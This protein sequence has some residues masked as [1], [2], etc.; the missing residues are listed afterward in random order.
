MS[1][2][3]FAEVKLV[4]FSIYLSSG[5]HIGTMQKT[6]GMRQ[7]I[8]R[9][10][11]D[12]ICVLDVRKTD[13]RVVLAAK[14]LSKYPPSDI[15]AVSARQYGQLPVQKFGEVTGIRT[16]IGRFIPGT[17]TNPRYQGYFEPKILIVTDPLAD[18]QP[19]KE[20]AEVGISTI[21]LCDSD[22][23]I[24]NLDLVI[25]TNNKGKKALALVYW[26]LARQLLLERGQ[27]QSAQEFSIP[28][29]EFEAPAEEEK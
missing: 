18:E 23:E 5:V 12:G 8:Y 3:E 29:Q 9:I 14:L 1:T 11:P 7:F 16:I 24:Q 2:Q 13:K 25:P 22:N 15:V 27:L 21:G 28:L 17:F 26:L 19:L 20:A 4:D 6:G 10:R